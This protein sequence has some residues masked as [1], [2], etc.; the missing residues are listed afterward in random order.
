MTTACCVSGLAQT[1]LVDSLHRVLIRQKGDTLEFTTRLNLANEYL[2]RDL[3]KAKQLAL[4]LIQLTDDDQKAKWRCAGFCYLVTINLQ[5]GQPDSARYF[6]SKAAQLVQQHPGN[7]RIQ[8]N[9][10]Q[11]AGFFYKETG[12]LKKAL[13]HML[14][15]IALWKKPDENRAGQFLNVGN[16]YFRMGDYQRAADSHLQAL[17]LFETLQNKRG[18][19]FCLQG[20]GN[21]FLK[22]KQYDQAK[23]YFEK[24]L[25]FKQAM[26][27]K[28]GLV[29]SQMGLGEV[30]DYKKE[31]PQAI[32]FFQRALAGAREMNLT[33]EEVS[34]LLR[35]GLLH[36]HMGDLTAASAYLNE[37]LAEAQQTSDSDLL[38]QV[39]AEKVGLRLAERE[40][41]SLQA[42]EGLLTKNLDT[43]IRTG[44]LAGQ[45]NCYAQL[46]ALYAQNQQYEKA[47][48]FLNQHQR[49]EDSLQGERVIMQI[50]DLEK[51]YQAD[52]RDQEIALLKKDQQLTTLALERQRINYLLAI[53][54]A[55]AALV[56][57]ALL[58]NRYR[59][60]N[61]IKRQWEIETMRQSIARDL[62]DD[63]GSALSSIN[64]MSELALREPAQAGKH[65]QNISHQASHMLETMSDIVWSINPKNDTAEQTAIK[66]REFAAELLES[67]N[68]ACRVTWPEALAHITLNTETRKNL[69]LIAKEA[70]N[71]AA[72]YS[73]ASDMDISFESIPGALR[74]TLS[75]NGKGF[76]TAHVRPGN[77][78]RNM[79]ERA[80]VMG[81]TFELTTAPNAGS[82]LRI[83]VPI[84]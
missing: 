84:T 5:T 58:V 11:A 43:Y 83:S 72:K 4:E 23:A 79:E 20:L 39:K 63:M 16:L 29:T 7:T 47:F 8:H 30:Y 10:N 82:Q 62:H 17:T 12:E 48:H 49:L 66:V 21:D 75:D 81:A 37:A 26:S 14:A 44:D 60:M 6:L 1:P 50:Q 18:Q 51:K 41:K 67:K 69:F 9:Y 33:R 28:R 73:G 80:R 15:N 40:Q 36:K 3:P 74:L 13:P 68:I 61:R 52:K 42:D 45:A 2:R 59:V 78:L 24:S 32:H 34:S 65:I 77:G 27:D 46:S 25:A 57:T 76:D 70:I 55:L 56:I 64:I 35:L 19:S 31:F 71:N 54:V 53:I 22:L 38:A